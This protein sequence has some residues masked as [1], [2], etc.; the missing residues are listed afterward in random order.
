MRPTTLHLTSNLAQNLVRTRLSPLPTLNT[1][2]R[3]SSRSRPVAVAT[4]AEDMDPAEKAAEL[5]RLADSPTGT[6][7][8]E[9][10]ALMRF[11]V[12]QFLGRHARSLVGLFEAGRE[13]WD[14]L[15][16][17]AAKHGHLREAVS[18]FK[19]AAGEEGEAWRRK[20]LVAYGRWLAEKGK[21]E[22][23]GS[24][25]AAA[26]E[27]ELAQAA[28]DGAGDWRMAMVATGRRGARGDAVERMAGGM[29]ERMEFVGVSVDERLT[30][31][32]QPP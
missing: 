11:R 7:R 1:N 3:K 6:L 2:T 23:A 25:L 9:A 8:E 28:F 21:Q 10:D 12:D 32:H 5:K 17:E 31:T 26:G 19:S 29:A 30:S 22:D 4:Q 15:L 14:L 18:L 20:A 27:W 13:H 24:V 16:Q